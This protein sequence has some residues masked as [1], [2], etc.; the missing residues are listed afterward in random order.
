MPMKK[1]F[2]VSKC[3]LYKLGHKGKHEVFV[4]RDND[5]ND[6]FMGTS[7][8]RAMLESRKGELVDNHK[9]PREEFGVYQQETILFWL[10]R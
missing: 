5:Q 6:R 4:V 8:W 10:T 1:V 2:Q 3:R 7:Y 9:C